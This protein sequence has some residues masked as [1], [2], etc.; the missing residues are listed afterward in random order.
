MRWCGDVFDMVALSK[1]I[2]MPLEGR[3]HIPTTFTRII[4][5][6]RS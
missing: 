4:G 6:G 2:E 5:S 1:G 3:M